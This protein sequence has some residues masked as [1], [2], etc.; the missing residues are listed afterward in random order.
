[1]LQDNIL[2]IL[3]C[4]FKQVDPKDWHHVGLPCNYTACKFESCLKSKKHAWGYV[5]VH[6]HNPG[7]IFFSI[8]GTTSNTASVTQS[9]HS[10]HGAADKEKGEHNN[11]AA[12]SPT[13]ELPTLD[14]SVPPVGQVPEGES[15][16][17]L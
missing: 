8:Q 17:T 7:I 5:N 3:R 11:T 15:T 6:R 10:A 2:V 16:A 14:P 9:H 4:N 12:E 13:T 1:M